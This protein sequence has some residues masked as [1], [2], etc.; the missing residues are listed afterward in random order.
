MCISELK[1]QAH[2]CMDKCW[3]R[4]GAVTQNPAAL[5]QCVNDQTPLIDQ[6]INCLDKNL[7]S[8]WPNANGPDIQKQDILKIVRLGEEKIESS[9]DAILSSPA[10]QPIQK[11]VHTALDFGMC[12]K[13]CFLQRNSAGFCFDRYG[14]QPL[15][16]EDRARKSLKKCIRTVDWKSKAGEFCDCSLHAG[17][18][19]L[20]NYCPMLRAMAKKIKVN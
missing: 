18:S 1:S 10:I 17:V 19:E 15:L 9:K 16:R 4:M 7:H 12:V 6:F 5:K 8:C 20:G 3:Y 11:L 13:D 2:Q 14:C